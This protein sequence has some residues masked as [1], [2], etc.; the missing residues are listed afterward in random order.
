MIP[1]PI[2]K[3][4]LSTELKFTSHIEHVPTPD[5]LTGKQMKFKC[6]IS[7]EFAEG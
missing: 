7:L 4:N 5:I 1:G 2:F 3:S 6:S